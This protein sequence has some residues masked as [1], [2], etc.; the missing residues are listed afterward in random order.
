M[1][2][3]CPPMKDIDSIKVS[4]SSDYDVRRA[5]KVPVCSISVASLT[6]PGGIFSPNYLLR[7][8]HAA[9][10]VDVRQR[11]EKVNEGTLSYR[12]AVQ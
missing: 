12:C 4:I 6:W 2:I 8:G 7:N 10:T 1:H 5:K 3:P 9:K 11:A